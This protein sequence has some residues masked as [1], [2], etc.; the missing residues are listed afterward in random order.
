MIPVAWALHN[1]PKMQVLMTPK[2]RHGYKL[3]NKATLQNWKDKV[4]PSPNPKY[5]KTPV[6]ESVPYKHSS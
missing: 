6:L 1:R 5:Q 2:Y 4:H 3:M